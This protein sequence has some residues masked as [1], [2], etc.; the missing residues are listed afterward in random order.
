MNKTFASAL[1]AVAASAASGTFDYKQNGA[2]WGQI[3]DANDDYP[4]Q[5]CDTGKEQ[6]PID[7]NWDVRETDKVMIDLK[8][9]WDYQINSGARLL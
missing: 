8:N 6:S 3:H 4:N 2:D 9:Y 7:L 1:L 5:L